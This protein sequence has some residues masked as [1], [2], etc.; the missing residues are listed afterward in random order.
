MIAAAKDAMAI[1]Q[2]TQVKGPPKLIRPHMPL[3]QPQLEM[4]RLVISSD[5]A[6][7]IPD[8]A[9]KAA[10]Q[11]QL[12]PT[13]PTKSNVDPDEKPE[14]YSG[15]A[16]KAQR[17]KNIVHLNEK[18]K[19]TLR[20]KKHSL[21]VPDEIE[22]ST[23]E[24]KDPDTAEELKILE[25][26]EAD[27]KPE[28]LKDLNA[29]N[30]SN[31]KML[32]DGEAEHEDDKSDS[33]MVV[34]KAS[35]AQHT[36]SMSVDILEKKPT[37]KQA[38]GLTTRIKTEVKTEPEA[39]VSANIHA[40]LKKGK[41]R[42]A[43]L[44]S[45]VLKNRIW[46]MKFLPCLMYW[47]GNSNYGWTIPETELES[48]LE[49]IFYAVYPHSKG[50]CSFEVEDLS[51]QLYETQ[52]AHEEY[53]K[54][55]LQECC[56][57]YEDPDNEEQPGIFLSEHILHI[58]AAHLIA[59]ARKVRVDLLVEFCK[60]GY[61]TTLAL[62]A[63]AAE[64]AL[65][66][67]KDQLLI[68]SNPTDNG[69]KTH[70]I[71]QTLNKLEVTNKMSHTRT[72]FSSGNWEMDTMAYMDSIKAL[73]HERIQEILEQLENYMKHPHFNHRSSADDDS[74][75]PEDDTS[76]FLEY[77]HDIIIPPH[78][79]LFRLVAPLHAYYTLFLSPLYHL[80]AKT[81]FLKFSNLLICS[82]IWTL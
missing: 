33:M 29:A 11:A 22:L 43:H 75:T 50:G 17:E 72:A 59:V 38:K 24:L 62:T 46:H 15:P 74:T 23:E 4:M 54:Y 71:V 49:S 9:E 25:D 80:D 64:H 6:G 55:Q 70:K 1:Q 21:P 10:S 30:D 56:F 35:M 40:K 69:G 68:D 53:A 36:S 42:N 76:F 18:P 28:N 61:Q 48:V 14:E 52:E 45:G 26:P 51:F 20:G 73:P 60:P 79:L 2:K 7:P 63:V 12:K 77:Y 66:L 82:I 78:F 37:T 39:V 44:P 81:T 34:N 13:Q 47:V 31:Y 32:E 57:I 67:V 65:I 16:P 5:L 8:W 19:V 3:K 41:A 27:E 58:F